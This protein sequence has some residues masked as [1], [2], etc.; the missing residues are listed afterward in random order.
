MMT[1][2][3]KTKAKIP[4]V[5]Q[6]QARKEKTTQIRLNENW[7]LKDPRSQMRCQLKPHP[8]EST[9][10]TVL[11]LILIDD[12]STPSIKSAGSC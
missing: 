12:G 11:E 9:K 4:T 5:F 8:N 10:N 1:N 6:N 7:K 2:H 3:L